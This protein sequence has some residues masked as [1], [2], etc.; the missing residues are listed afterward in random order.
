MFLDKNLSHQQ[1]EAL[2]FLYAFMP[3]SDLA[4]YNGDFF[5]ANTDI[6][7]RTRN[8]APWGKDIPEDIFLHYVLPCR[9]NNENLDSFRIV[10]YDEITD[11]ISGMNMEQAALEINHWCHEKVT[12]QP[13]DIRTSGPMST[14]LSARGRCGEE[15]T[16]TVA[17]FAQLEFRPDRSIHPAGLIPMIIMPG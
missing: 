4:D 12:Y 8:E 14:I 3:L 1:A 11:R 7:L 16:F 2:K 15:S 9:V 17:H 10:Y 13:A 5:L 6:A